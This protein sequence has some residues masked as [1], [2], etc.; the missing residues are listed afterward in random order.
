MA[1][2]AL[3]VL[4]CLAPS[5]DA[6]TFDRPS[7]YLSLF[8]DYFPNRGDTTELRA[9]VFAEQKVSATDHVRFTFSGFAEALVARRPLG[10]DARRERVSD[11]V[12]HAHEATVELRFRR[13]DLY[14]GY[15]RVVWGRLDELQPTDVINPLDISTVLLRG[16]QRGAAAGRGH[17]RAALFHRGRVVEGVYVPVFRRGRF[18]QLEEPSSPFNLLPT[19]PRALEPS[20]S[21]SNAQGGARFNATSGRVDWSVSAYRGFEP[22]GTFRIAPA[23]SVPPV[24]PPSAI[25]E[26]VF[27]RFTMIGGDFETVS[28]QWG[29]RGEVA[30]FVGDNF[31]A[32]FPTPALVRGNSVDAGVGWTARPETIASAAL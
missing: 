30:A 27:P 2:T 31:Q 28:G 29:I 32:V 20:T 18:D 4:L 9:R 10:A 17:A 16:P 15:G 25:V 12:A 1:G 8:A 19:L 26:Q 6:Q 11:A 21:F 7:G 22:F 5:A 13:F 3:G 24:P 23:G 14:A